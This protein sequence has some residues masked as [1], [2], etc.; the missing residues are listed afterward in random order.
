MNLW[1]L[2]GENHFQDAIPIAG[3]DALKVYGDGQEKLRSKAPKP[4]SRQ[5]TRWM[6]SRR[7]RLPPSLHHQFLAGHREAEAFGLN[8][9]RSFSRRSTKP[10]AVS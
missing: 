6:P 5:K 3:L 1:G 4:I 2:P 7:R 9:S 8:A 10:W